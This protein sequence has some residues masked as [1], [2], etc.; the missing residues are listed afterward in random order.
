VA[1]TRR[2]ARPAIGPEIVREFF[3]SYWKT[4]SNEQKEKTVFA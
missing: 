2:E 1:A 3:I 4:I